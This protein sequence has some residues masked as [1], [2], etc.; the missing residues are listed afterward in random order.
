MLAAFAE[1]N[2]RATGCAWAAVH[3]PAPGVLGAPEGAP[4]DRILVSAAAPVVPPAL[5]EQL[6]DPGRMVLPVAGRMTL[7]VRGQGREEITRHGYYRFVPLV[8]T[9]S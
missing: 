2:L 5:L 3:E 7:V 1:E 9:E 8:E 4:Y 6:A